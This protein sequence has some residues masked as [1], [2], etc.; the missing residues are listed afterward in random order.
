MPDDGAIEPGRSD[1]EDLLAARRQKLEALRVAGTEPYLDAFDVTARS[2]DLAARFS[3]LEPGSE[4]DEIVSVAGRLVARRDQGKVAFLVIRD[5]T[6]DLQLFCRQN[7]LGDVE[8]E[9]ATDLDLGDWI[10]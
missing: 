8:F 2:A 7:V 4:T 10:G 9:R 3:E 6:G 1:T 5:A